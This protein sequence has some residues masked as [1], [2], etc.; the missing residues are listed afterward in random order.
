MLLIVATLTR[1]GLDL[2]YEVIGSGP[3]LLLPKFNYSRWGR[4]LDLGLLAGRFTVVIASPRGFAD[5]GRLTADGDYRVADLADD[6]VA[7]ME[8]AGFERFSVFGYSFTGAFAPWLAHLTN[9]VDAV[10]SGGFQIVGDYSPLYPEV[11]GLTEAAKADPAAWADLN[12]HFDNRVGLEFYREL[13]EL[14]PD[15]L[16][17]N[18]PCPLFAFWGEDDEEIAKGGGVQLLASGLDRRGLKHASFP[19]HDHDGMLVHLNEA[20]PSVLAWFDELPRTG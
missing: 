16:V 11:Q 20:V 12:S 18:L 14:P 1:D 2:H 6:L 8:M 15:F 7:V 19:G 13:S 10:V 5:S 4:Y 3:A 9:R 17:D